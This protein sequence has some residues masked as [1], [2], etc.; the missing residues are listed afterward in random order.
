M[1]TPTLRIKSTW[2]KS[3]D[4]R[5]P[6]EHASAM[7]FIVFRVAGQVLKRMRGADFDIDTGPAYFAF[8]RECL[9]FLISVVDRQASGRL[10]PDERQAF[11]V[12]LVRHVA[13]ILQDNESDLL[14][15]PAPGDASHADRFVDLVNEVVAHYAEFGSDPRASADAGFRPDFAYLRYF[16]HRLEPTV[17]AKD[18]LWVVDQVVAIEG[19]DAVD[20]VA[21]ALRS[22]FD[23][24][25]RPARRGRLS[26]D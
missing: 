11:T 18:R 7:A 16:G 9:V 26:G 14:G 2:F 13:R 15:P 10:D 3:G 17:P 21:G 22:L 6:A 25:P 19:P 24:A 23:P 4:K 12:A 20:V 5:S 8:L 1:T